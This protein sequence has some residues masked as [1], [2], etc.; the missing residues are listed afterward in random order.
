MK[1]EILHEINDILSN[2]TNALNA[3]RSTVFLVNE[4]TGTL[5]SLVSQ[6]IRNNLISMPL[7]CGIAGYTASN[8][9]ALVVNNVSKNK[10]FNPYFD[11]ITGFT[12]EKILCTPILTESGRVVGVI[13]SLNKI[14]GDFSQ[15]DL[16]ILKSF[17]DA[18]ALA[19]K[20]AKLYASAESIK[21][22][23]ATLLKVSSSINSELDLGA[24]IQL[25]IEKAS[26]ITKSDRS[27]FF[28]LDKEENVLWTK[29][30]EGLDGK[31]IKTNKGLA[32]NVATSK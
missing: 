31:I 15:H 3:Q 20:N 25:I 9:K 5:D 12:T 32:Y 30:G 26:E 23:I 16:T 29:F 14:E 4:E 28:L 2:I 1:R 17:A 13:Q 8:G 19:I 27:S 22:N 21:N 11:T 18:I 7:D 24:L 10:H 6:G